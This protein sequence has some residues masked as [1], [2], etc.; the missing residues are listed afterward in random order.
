RMLETAIAMAHDVDDPTQAAWGM[1]FPSGQLGSYAWGWDLD[2]FN[3]EGGPE[4]TEAYQTGIVTEVHYNRPEMVEYFQWLVDLTYRHGVAPRPSDT[5]AIEQ[6][7]GWPMMSGRIGMYI[8][9]AWSF[10]DFASVQPEWEW[11]V[12]AIP[13]GPAGIVKPPLFND[14]WMLS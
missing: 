9:G 11:G 2:P 1:V 8:Q 7:V 3:A 6:T 14:S 13:H 4:L 5:D 12:A 10:T